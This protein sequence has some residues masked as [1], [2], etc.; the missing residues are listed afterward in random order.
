MVHLKNI[1]IFSVL[2][3]KKEKR[4][5]KSC[6]VHYLFLCLRDELK[7]HLSIYYYHLSIWMIGVKYLSSANCVSFSSPA[8]ATH[9]L[10]EYAFSLQRVIQSRIFI[11]RQ[12][13]LMP[14]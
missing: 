12:E 2:H 3:E 11:M 13:M 9:L 8:L 14:F 1:L 7:F 4:L 5:G 10:H 6:Y